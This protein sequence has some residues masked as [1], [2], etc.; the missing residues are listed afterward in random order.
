MARGKSWS[1]EEDV[2][3]CTAW[4]QVSQ[5]S[6]KGTDQSKETFW[7]SIH[8]VFQELTQVYDA[9]RTLDSLKCRWKDINQEVNRF[10]GI[11]SNLFEKNISGTTDEDILNEAEKLYNAVAKKNFAY[12]SSYD[13]LTQHEKW[14]I[15]KTKR[16]A[17]KRSA[18]KQGSSDE[19]PNGKESRPAGAKKQRQNEEQAKFHSEVLSNQ[20]RVADALEKRTTLMEKQFQLE[21]TNHK[22]NHLISLY[23]MPGVDEEEKKEF[24]R[25]LRHNMKNDLIIRQNSGV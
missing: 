11:V 25:E 2:T 18:E 23:N 10:V 20:K 3:L 6:I 12:H 17:E 13:I 21:E 5:D 4:L 24:F 22:I 15:R 9:N 14:K 7:A 1:S 19:K 16:S 8:A